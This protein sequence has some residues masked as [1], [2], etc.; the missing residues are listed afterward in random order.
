MITNCC[1][2]QINSLNGPWKIRALREYNTILATLCASK[3]KISKLKMICK[4]T[5]NPSAHPESK[6][7]CEMVTTSS[8]LS[9]VR[10]DR[11]CFP[12][13]W[14]YH[15]LRRFFSTTLIYLRSLVRVVYIQAITESYIF[16]ISYK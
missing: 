8:V 4:K 5:R 9:I 15:I 16:I 12:W 7:T 11:I 3:Q 2:Y 14:N 13:T 1:S 10:T 6:V